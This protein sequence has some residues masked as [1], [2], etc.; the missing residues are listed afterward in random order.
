MRSWVANGLSRLGWKLIE[1]GFWV[2]GYDLKEYLN[3]N[4]E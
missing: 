4:K 3:R 1:V 2:E